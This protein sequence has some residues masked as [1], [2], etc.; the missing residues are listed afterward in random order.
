[1]LRHMQT[2][3]ENHRPKRGDEI[4]EKKL[5]QFPSRPA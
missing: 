4:D 3:R 1:M 2:P 5:Q